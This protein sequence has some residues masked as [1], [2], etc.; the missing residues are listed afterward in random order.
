MRSVLTT[1]L[2]LA[3][4]LSACDM[5][6][7][8]LSESSNDKSS[9]LELRVKPSEAL[10]KISKTKG[11]K[12]VDRTMAVQAYLQQVNADLVGRG[13]SIAVQKVEWVGGGGRFEAGQTVYANDR[14]LRIAAQWVPGDPE[15]M[16]DGNNITYV[17]DKSFAGANSYNPIAVVDAEPAIDASFETWNELACSNLNIVKREDA[18]GTNYSVLLN[19]GDPVIDPFHADISTIG[20][21][22]GAI[23]DAVLGPGAS[24]NVLGVTITF[25][26]IDEDGNPTDVNG[27]GYDDTALVEVWYNDNFAWSTD[28]TLNDIETVALHENGHALG[29]GHFGKVFVTE[30]NNKLHVSPRAVMN[31]FIL[32]DLHNPLGTD[33]GAFCGLYASWP[34]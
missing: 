31:A 9:V 27:D 12:G 10:G 20:F 2:L 32:G 6:D 26:W 15:R 4:M 33:N 34:N 17:V 18:A 11:V 28:G 29:L 22:P 23:F 5:Q 25:V 14:E 16:A 7:P 8:Q 21:L 3:L 30:K 24:S 13:L 1:V 19:T